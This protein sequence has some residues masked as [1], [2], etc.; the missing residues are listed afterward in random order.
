M[1]CEV[2]SGENPAAGEVLNVPCF[3]PARYFAGRC[4]RL[5]TFEAVY[6]ACWR[7]PALGHFMPLL[8]PIPASAANSE[9]DGDT[10]CGWPGRFLSFLTVHRPYFTTSPRRRTVLTASGQCFYCRGG[11]GLCQWG[12][13]GGTTANAR[14]LAGSTTFQQVNIALSSEV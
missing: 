4:L 12:R 1:V 10:A 9:R 6:N 2:L 8:L 7:T 5:Q 11:T 13:A 3:P 14:D